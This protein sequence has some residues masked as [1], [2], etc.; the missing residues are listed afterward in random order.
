[1]RRL[2]LISLVLVAASMVIAPAAEACNSLCKDQGGGCRAC[3]FSLFCNNCWC[4]PIGQCHCEDFICVGE[5][6]PSDDLALTG[7][8]I[9]ALLASAGAC[10][11]SPTM[12]ADAGSPT[13]RIDTIRVHELKP[14]T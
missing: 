3:G 2:L 8:P 6:A 12:E 5:E 13:A 4:V 10:Q 9:D 14:R 1:M 7:L 11:A